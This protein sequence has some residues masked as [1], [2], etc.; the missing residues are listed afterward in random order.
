VSTV[1]ICRERE[2]ESL[3]CCIDGVTYTFEVQSAAMLPGTPSEAVL[4]IGALARNQLGPA[5]AARIRVTATLEN[6]QRVPTLL[7]KV[8]EQWLVAGTPTGRSL[9]PLPI[10]T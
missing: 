7:K 2:I 9:I 6:L 10:I 4:Q 1:D 8:L 3:S 5:L